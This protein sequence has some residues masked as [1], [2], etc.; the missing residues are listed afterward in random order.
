MVYDE[1]LK[2]HPEKTS[3]TMMQSKK[4]EPDF[5]QKISNL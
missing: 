1:S 3:S 4:K 2:Y 5:K